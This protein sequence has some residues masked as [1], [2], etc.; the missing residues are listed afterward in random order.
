MT[1]LEDLEKQ[2]QAEEFNHSCIRRDNIKY[3]PSPLY[4]LIPVVIFFDFVA[5]FR[6]LFGFCMGLSAVIIFY[7]LV[8]FIQSGKVT[9][10]TNR[11]FV[12]SV[13]INHL[14]YDIVNETRNN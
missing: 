12:S 7:T 2:L 3:I 9:K 4:H 1:R 10:N 13:R 6:D 14:R 5:S 8:F 11:L